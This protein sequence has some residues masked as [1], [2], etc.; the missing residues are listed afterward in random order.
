[1]AF[2][3][4]IGQK[5]AN[6]NPATGYGEAVV[7]T[8]EVP[9]SARGAEYIMKGLDRMS[10]NQ[11]A[12]KQ[13]R[14]KGDE[15][16]LQY[17]VKN[18]PNYNKQD[19]DEIQANTKQLFGELQN[20]R[21][22]FGD[23][24]SPAMSAKI[25]ANM[26][27]R[28]LSEQRSS[29]IKGI[30]TTKIEAPYIKEDLYK[31]DELQN[32]YNTKLQDYPNIKRIDP[33]DSKYFDTPIYIKDV[34]KDINQSVFSSDPKINTKYNGLTIETGETGY[35]FKKPV[36][37]RQ[38]NTIGYERGVSE[39][40]RGILMEN[41]NYRA[42][43]NKEADGLIKLQVTQFRGQVIAGKESIPANIDINSDSDV[44]SYLKSRI[45]NGIDGETD[46]VNDAIEKD[47][48]PYEQLK[49]EKKTSYQNFTKDDGGGKST[50]KIKDFSI[51]GKTTD[52]LNLPEKKISGE[53]A[54]T[55]T[56]KSRI[57]SVFSPG[58]YVVSGIN[59]KDL[60][61]NI[62]PA[63]IIDAS[64][65]LVHENFAN[66][67]V[68]FNTVKYLPTTKQGGIINARDKDYLAKNAERL[69]YGGMQAFVIGSAI[70]ETGVQNYLNDENNTAQNKAALETVLHNIKNDEPTGRIPEQFNKILRPVRIR[71]DETIEGIIGYN[72]I[73]GI[74][75][76]DTKV[77]SEYSPDKFKSKTSKVILTLPK[78][79]ADAN[80]IYNSLKS[81]ESFIDPN[82]IKRK[83]P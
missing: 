16:Y 7:G 41:P 40:L 39:G 82:G 62:N 51:I 21:D 42:K 56:G 13:A 59:G 55:L 71:V 54:G 28:K 73:K 72:K 38:G 83:K 5:L 78:S 46:A 70:D 63:K 53:D 76:L 17:I 30:Q 50:S 75:D 24:K 81:G 29:D 69:N 67:D 14:Q 79:K 68:K 32:I 12:E 3:N 23:L 27:L 58:G 26:D 36:L 4:L 20:T 57:V 35:R 48:F 22:S 49:Q 10:I 15:E 77:R 11:D 8:S 61:S 44:S 34:I 64:T 33:S 6:Y 60:I 2:E 37:D 80:K 31:A 1:M 25:Q 47:L 19:N 43:I 9:S 74:K 66:Q 18:L 65:G 52:N 45:R